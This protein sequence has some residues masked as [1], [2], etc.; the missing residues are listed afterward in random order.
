MHD[1]IVLG[2]ALDRDVVVRDVLQHAAGIALQR[3]AEAAAAG[4]RP[5]EDVAGADRHIGEDGAE[6]L[7]PSA[8][9][10]VDAEA[11]RHRRQAALD[12]PDDRPFAV[13]DVGNDG[14]FGLEHD[15]RL[16]HADAAAP[17]ARARPNP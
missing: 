15:R 12:A 2:G 5:A 11:M 17:F 3:I 1:A 14:L 13:A 6:P 9:A 7:F 4:G 10:R 8:P 16:A